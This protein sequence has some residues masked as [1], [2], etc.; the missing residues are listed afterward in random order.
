[1]ATGESSASGLFFLL[2]GVA[3]VTVARRRR[4]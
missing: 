3:L 1:M 4:A 2:L